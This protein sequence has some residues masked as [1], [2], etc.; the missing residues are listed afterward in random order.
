LSGAI[1]ILQS[2]RCSFVEKNFYI[3]NMSEKTDLKVLKEEAVII[4]RVWLIGFIGVVWNGDV[5]E[6]V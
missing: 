1:S 2:F 4:V 5:V 3:K 6:N